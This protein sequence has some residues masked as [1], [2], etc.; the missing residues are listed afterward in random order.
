MHHRALPLLSRLLLVGLPAVSLGSAGCAYNEGLIIQ[1][2]RGT[3]HIP[4]DAASRTI[5]SEDGTETVIEHD[6]RLLG[7]VY[8]GLYP[9][10]QPANMAERYPYPEVGPQFKEDVPGDTYPYGGTTVGDLRFACFEF[11]T[12]KVT[13]GRF[14]DYQ[15]LV[16]WFA[17]IGTPLL[18]AADVEVTDGEFVRQTCYDLLNA[19]TDD[20]VRITAYEDRNGDGEIGPADLDFVYDESNDEFVGEFTLWQQ[21]MFWDQAQENCTPGVDCTGFS[22]W[23]FMDAPSAESY[24]YSTCEAAQ[25]LQMQV[26]NQDFNGGRSWNNVLNFPSNYITTGDDVSSEPFVWSNIEATPEFKLDFVVD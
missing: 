25:G 19:T 6:L 18:D 23:G 20:E 16:D 24:T 11:L 8:L 22:L 14:A 7:P 13:S 3:V 5:V 9:S 21:E 2:M 12:C 15:D 4:G 26:Y 10:V 17:L 1:N